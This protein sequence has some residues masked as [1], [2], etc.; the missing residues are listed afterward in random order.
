MRWPEVSPPASFCVRNGRCLQSR[1]QA[2]RREGMRVLR[3]SSV[4]RIRSPETI[5]GSFGPAPAAHRL[6]GRG[7]EGSSPTSTER[8]APVA[9]S[10][11]EALPLPGCREALGWLARK[12][13]PVVIVSARRLE[14]ARAIA[15]VEIAVLG[16]ETL[17]GF[18]TAVDVALQGPEEMETSLAQSVDE[19]P[20]EEAS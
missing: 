5:P 19:F 16:A 6:F 12:P 9:P 7:R 3:A 8:S 11:G 15:G 20:E 1:E 13:G 2:L 14:S 4:A 17:N 10:P 18:A